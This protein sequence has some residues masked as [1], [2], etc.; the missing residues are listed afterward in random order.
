MHSL[1]RRAWVDIDLGALLRNGTTVAAHAGVPLLPMVKADAY[2]L[3]A[4][5]VAR[6]L[7]QLNPWGFG[8]ATIGEGEELRRAAIARPVLV[9]TPLLVE[10]FDAAI[11]ADLTPTL[12]DVHSITRWSETGRPW[13]LAVDTG[14][15]RAGVQ[16][17]EIDALLAVVRDVPPQGVFTHFHSAERNDATRAVQEKRF[18]EAVARLPVRPPMVHAENSPAVEHGGASEWSVVRPGVF[19]YGVSSGNSPQIRP[20]QVASLR[21]RVV[22]LRTIDD[23][24]TV[25]Y[26]GTYRA[27]GTRR[28]ATLAIGYADGYRRVLGNRASVLLRGKRAP[29]AGVVTMDMTMVDVTDVECEVGDVATLIGADGDERIDV[30]DVA[31]LGDLSPYEVLTGLR[32]RLPRRYVGGEG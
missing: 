9:F 15:S 1:M 19:L 18:A 2:G 10:E 26:G 7:E 21:A 29:V 23:G 16:W 32:G 27:A 30:T 5:R 3:G 6:T 17:N 12:G 28:I 8:V 22:D 11:R 24:E 31:A 13:Q 20:E 4:V 14:M 25:S